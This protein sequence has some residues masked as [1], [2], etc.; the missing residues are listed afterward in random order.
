MGIA[1]QQEAPMSPKMLLRSLAILLAAL[2]FVA[3]TVAA[4]DAPSVA[5]AAR[6]A[7]QQKRD[8]PKPAHVIDN[9]SFPPSHTEPADSSGS[10]FS[11]SP[12]PA[13]DA[14]APASGDKAALT[15]ESTATEGDAGEDSKKAEIAAL[16]Q[17]IADLKEKVNL[18]QRDI[19]LS[20]DTFLSNPDH[21]H[22]K[23]GKEKLDSMNADLTQLQSQLADLLNK[24]N[25]LGGSADRKAPEVPKS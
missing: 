16:K 7:R 13:A 1:F 4:Q 19:G 14:T 9:D 24:L 12:T 25:A 5:E 6:R 23:A 20:Q 8:A 11:T 21:E 22:D 3:A 18:Q 2:S 17:Q 15:P 10:A